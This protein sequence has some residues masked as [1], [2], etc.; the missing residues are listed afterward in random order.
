MA[1]IGQVCCWDGIGLI[2]TVWNLDWLCSEAAKLH[3]LCGS[4]QLLALPAK[5]LDLQQHECDVC[6]CVLVATGCHCRVL[7]LLR[8]A[9]EDKIASLTRQ[10]EEATAKKE[11]LAK[12]VRSVR[13]CERPCPRAMAAASASGL[14]NAVLRERSGDGNGM[15]LHDGHLHSLVQAIECIINSDQSQA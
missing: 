11:A 2:R 13:K 14:E 10:F 7:L 3:N 5:Q 15:A 4:V 1:Q 6:A 8:Q 9:V 12:Q